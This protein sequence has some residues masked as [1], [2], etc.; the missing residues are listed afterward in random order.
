M[1]PG[2]GTGRTI[3]EF[4]MPG[5][6]GD[7]DARNLPLRLLSKGDAPVLRG[8]RGAWGKSPFR[9]SQ[10]ELT[11]EDIRN[12]YLPSLLPLPEEKIT[13]GTGPMGDVARYQDILK[14]ME[15][16]RKAGD[17]RRYEE[18]RQ[19][20]EDAP[21]NIASR[22]EISSPSGM[23]PRVMDPEA[24]Q[25]PAGQPTD[26]VFAEDVD[27]I[28]R[29]GLA[30]AA[31]STLESGTTFLTDALFQQQAER[32]LSPAESPGGYISASMRGDEEEKELRAAAPSKVY[33]APRKLNTA[34]DTFT[35]SFSG[36]DG[37]LAEKLTEAN[38]KTRELYPEIPGWFYTAMGI[39]AEEGLLLLAT[40]GGS[41]SVAL[42]KQAVRLIA[43]LDD[44]QK[45]S[46]KALQA[47]QTVLEGTGKTLF[48][49]G[50]ALKTPMRLENY[51]GT[52]AFRGIGAAGRAVGAGTRRIS[53]FLSETPADAA[54]RKQA[55]EA[56]EGPTEP[57][58]DIG[59]STTPELLPAIREN[60][61]P[62]EIVYHGS[63]NVFEV[64]EPSKTRDTALYGP[65]A[66]F[67]EDPSVASGYARTRRQAEA[68]PNVT[69][70][71]LNN[72]KKIFD[73][74]APADK[75]IL[76]NLQKLLDEDDVMANLIDDGVER[77]GLDFPQ[78]IK[79]NKDLYRFLTG[80]QGNERA[81]V[82]DMLMDYGFDAIT[83]IGGGP[84]RTAP[85]R[86]WIVLPT[87]LDYTIPK[88][89]INPA[90]GKAAT[91]PT[92]TATDDLVTGTAEAEIAGLQDEIARLSSEMDDLAFRGNQEELT[93]EQ[94]LEANDIFLQKNDEL[95]AAQDRLDSLLGSRADTFDVTGTTTRQADT[96]AGGTGDVS[97]PGGATITPSE[98]G[99]PAGRVTKVVNQ[100]ANNPK[101]RKTAEFLHD[102]H[103]SLYQLASRTTAAMTKGLDEVL[104]KYVPSV[105]EELRNLLRTAPGAANAGA[106]RVNTFAKTLKQLAP[107]VDHSKISYHTALL[108]VKEVFQFDS[109]AATQLSFSLPGDTKP[110]KFASEAD[111]DNAIATLQQELGDVQFAEVLAGTKETL[112]LYSAER[113]RMLDAGFINKK[114]FDLW[115]SSQPLY[116]PFKYTE[117]KSRQA[118]KK[119]LA[120]KYE[121]IG[122]RNSRILDFGVRDLRATKNLDKSNDPL[123]DV[124]PVQ[125]VLNSIKEKSNRLADTA[126]R[127]LEADDPT[128]VRKL[129][130]IDEEGKLIPNR[131]NKDTEAKIKVFRN[132]EMEEYAVPLWFKKELVSF[133]AMD[134]VILN[135]TRWLTSSTD[136]T[137]RLLTSA[138]PLFYGPAFLVDLLTA[139]IGRGVNPFSATFG[140][141]I[142]AFARQFDEGAINTDQI[143]NDAM[144]LVGG[145]QSRSG[146][147]TAIQRQAGTGPQVRN[148]VKAK[149]KQDGGEVVFTEDVNWVAQ[150]NGWAA[151]AISPFEAVGEMVEQAPRRA[152]FRRQL[153]KRVPGWKKMT[154]EE[155]ALL[156]AVQEAAGEAI[157]LT[158]N[159]NRGARLTKLLNP[160]TMFI[161]ASFEGFK[162]PFRQMITN[163][164]YKKGAQARFA[165]LM[166]ATAGLYAYNLSYPEYRD[167]PDDIKLGGLVVM[168]PSFL[169]EAE[170]DPISGR[171]KPKYIAIIPK[172]R[173]WAMFTA[174]LHGA[175]EYMAANDAKTF[176]GLMKAM[177]FAI[178]TGWDVASPFPGRRGIPSLSGDDLTATTVAYAP[179]M[180]GALIELA[181][182]KDYYFDTEIN[183]PDIQG[184][185]R[186]GV[187]PY[188]QRPSEWIADV[189]NVLTAPLGVVTEF[190]F[191]KDIPD[192]QPTRVQHG[193]NS[194]FGGLGRMSFDLV[195]WVADV[196]DPRNDPKIE[197]MLEK[198]ETLNTSQRRTYLNS[199]S[200]EDR[201]A[202]L[203]KY[204]EPDERLP[205][206]GEVAR[207]F[208][209]QRTG[210]LRQRGL[211]QAASQTGLSQDDYKNASKEI[212][213]IADR[214]FREKKELE[215]KV[216]IPGGLTKE[217]FRGKLK[218]IT[219][220]QTESYQKLEAQYPN[221]PQFTKDTAKKEEFFSIL[222]TAGGTIEDPRTAGQQIADQYYSI[223]LEE[224]GQYE[225]AE[226]SPAWGKFFRERDAF[227]NSLSSEQRAL[228]DFEIASRETPLER[229]LTQVQRQLSEYWEAGVN[230]FIER[231][232]RQ[233]GRMGDVRK[234]MEA[235]R[236]LQDQMID[237]TVGA[238]GDWKFFRQIKEAFDISKSRGIIKGER[239]YLLRQKPELDRLLKEWGYKETPLRELEL[240]IR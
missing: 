66:Y 45:F 49:T 8:A 219:Q 55:E 43:K 126:L 231:I 194:L 230:K 114:E 217:Q 84:T 110:R 188:T 163:P 228:L 189:T 32:A 204:R 44:V 54:I 221:A 203:F 125:I 198:Y 47:L 132:G 236:E 78:D 149:I 42:G 187:D 80:M 206:V 29:P 60:P 124:M 209:P 73:I 6:R 197:K 103:F 212:R 180:L 12:P 179:P 118:R 133:N 46:P 154:A 24:M 240:S 59:M 233:S 229:E 62:T 147:M 161:N 185:P 175:M 74:D 120:G 9:G 156:P 99:K 128:I 76:D 166:T 15:E 135:R 1:K 129:N 131:F 182:N 205:I 238:K 130:Q 58:V 87:A 167:I 169:G 123:Q 25:L 14:L 168:L 20:L 151:K 122:G 178:N 193:A 177:G 146:G 3:P 26:E 50:A 86:V 145:E 158:I 83:H 104:D 111:V 136:M 190:L 215:A 176:T 16:A 152:F 186:E 57:D 139:F 48:L 52:Q 33:D 98:P 109:K 220:K 170:I 35:S 208:D 162:I 11:E 239:D 191:D 36:T 85:H 137:R 100:V 61:Q 115:E 5:P 160:Y 92:T 142:R 237:P 67:T 181:K 159:F 72:I 88:N 108:R 143:A 82:N 200:V 202:L 232:G 119:T 53:G 90:I 97:P 75:G 144:R 153:D 107:T 173:E 216:D 117:T 155:L 51:L 138:N 23:F 226:E 31:L 27:S 77:T 196:L 224:E 192:I 235:T 148:L 19:M 4:A 41:L 150:V 174:P 213:D 222:N 70:V 225:G 69:P 106:Q 17:M 10:P 201:D 94:L 141:A 234:F 134:N 218:K 210:G 112:N 171:K 101:V 95:R 91:P 68:A 195:D 105:G 28:D 89:I 56:L 30:G 93:T 121:K 71:R 38:Q 63:Q 81:E 39:V 96:G 127:A 183:N 22:K 207:R 2:E 65:G 172:I 140:P 21:R 102:R 214:T 211:Q 40:G 227:R 34:I 223:Q 116:S 157:E 113:K 199:I 165:G 7:R 164:R 37:S 18:L 64:F 13:Y 79:T 184:A